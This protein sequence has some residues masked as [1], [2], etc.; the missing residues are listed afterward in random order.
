MIFKRLAGI[1]NVA[2]LVPPMVRLISQQIFAMFGRKFQQ[3]LSLDIYIELNNEKIFLRRFVKYHVPKKNY[4]CL[5]SWNLFR[6]SST[7]EDGV[8]V[9]YLFACPEIFGCNQF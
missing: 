4:I 1:P 2:L 9:V 6:V 8:P 3:K 7:K 5:H